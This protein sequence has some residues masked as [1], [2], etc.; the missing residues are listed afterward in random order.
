L[1]LDLKLVDHDI[2]D[3]NKFLELVSSKYLKRYIS[4]ETKMI[5]I[6]PHVWARWL[7]KDGIL[8]LFDIPYFGRTAEINACV[9]M[10]LS[11]IH[12]GYLW[13]DRS[14]SL[15]TNCIVCIVGLR[16]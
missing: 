11:G 3:E 8:I 15:D 9:K 2:T 5:M 1:V 13:I 7:E 14:V 10:L 4:A 6:E 16:L 12:R